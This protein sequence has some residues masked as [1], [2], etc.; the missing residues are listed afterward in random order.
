MKTL[1][2]TIILLMSS[3]AFAWGPYGPYGPYGPGYGYGYGYPYG[4]M[5]A[6][7]YGWGIQ[8]PSFNYNTV[9]QQSPPIIINN[10]EQAPQ[11]ERIVV[12]EREV[13]NYECERLRGYFRKH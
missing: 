12:E 10:Q 13:C 2:C 5:G 1:L 4:M 6:M 9:I 3:S 11:R 7:G 8:A